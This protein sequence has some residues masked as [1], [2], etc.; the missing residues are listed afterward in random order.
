MKYKLI[1]ILAILFGIR[2]FHILAQV[3]Y[4]RGFRLL[5]NMLDG[6]DTADLSKAVFSVENAY[7]EGNL[8]QSAF[9]SRIEY[10][11]GICRSLAKNRNII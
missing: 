3:D 2:N 4:M 11:A 6:T 8:A 5:E 10:Y 1:F 7:Y 9:D